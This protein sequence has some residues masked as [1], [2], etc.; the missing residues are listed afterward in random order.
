MHEQHRALQKIV[1]N[2]L[3]LPFKLYGMIKTP[4]VG[5]AYMSERIFAH[6]RV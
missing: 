2:D 6:N 1:N 4:E 5:T 3:N